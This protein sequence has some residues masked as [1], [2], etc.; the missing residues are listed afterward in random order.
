[1]RAS[2]CLGTYRCEERQ[3]LRKEQERRRQHSMRKSASPLL[4]LC[5]WAV[6]A[7]VVNAKDITGTWYLD[8]TTYNSTNIPLLE[9]AVIDITPISEHNT[10]QVNFTWTDTSGVFIFED[11]IEVSKE[12]R[13]EIQQPVL[14]RIWPYNVYSGIE[15][16][17]SDYRFVKTTGWV[18]EKRMVFQVSGR[19]LTQQGFAPST[20]Y[21]TMDYESNFDRLE[22]SVTSLHPGALLEYVIYQRTK[23]VQDWAPVMVD[24]RVSAL[25]ESQNFRS[26]ETTEAVP[27]RSDKGSTN[28]AYT[29]LLSDAW[30]LESEEF[31][32]NALVIGLQGLVNRNNGAK[33]YLQYPPTWAYSYTPTVQ[34]YFQ[35]RHHF[36]FIALNST[37]DA[38]KTLHASAALKGY[39]IWDIQVRESLVVAYTIAGVENA[40]VVS[41]AQVPLMKAL[42]LPMLVNLTNQFRGLSPVD[43]YSWAK[44]KYW[45]KTS[46]KYLV[47]AGGVGGGSMHPGIMDYGVSEQAFFTDL[48]TLPSDTGEY[49]LAS[50]L[51]SSMDD[52]FYLLGWHS[53][54]KDFEHTFTTLAS[55]YGGRV[56]G[57]NTNPNLSFQSKVSV[58]PGFVFKNN[59]NIPSKKSKLDHTFLE[60]K[61]DEEKTYIL[62]VQTDG[63]GLGAWSKPGR[64]KIPYTWEVT[65]PDLEIQPALLQMFYEQSTEKDFF[66]GALGGPGYTYPNAVPK[67]LL[68]KR[69]QMAASMMSTLDL[70]SFVIFDASRA[71]GTHTVT[72]DTNLDE[73]VVQTYFDAMPNVKGFFNGYAPSF[74]FATSREEHGSRRSLVSFNY[75]LDP[76]RSVESAVKDLEDLSILNK[77]RPFFLEIHVREFSTVGKANDIIQQLSN[78]TFEVLP[79][80]VFVE[81]MN[82][83]GNL[84]ARSGR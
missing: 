83:C 28:T 71:V 34:K 11:S 14:S 38:L 6:L 8:K 39:V 3:R 20:V 53:Y 26:P 13:D 44:N 76:S 5:S 69:L 4:A 65:L 73:D 48:S 16:N 24:A 68:P 33:L 72:G 12:Y 55:K 45:D 19:L 43:I 52:A 2:R 78:Q 37:L 22:F 27:V 23:T 32:M 82:K 15:Y 79:G 36:D 62:L 30:K 42:G 61:C 29:V 10:T 81:T 40:L 59:R 41:A 18:N 7:Y 1:M 47:W 60:K 50:S 51:V 67:K 63:L 54:E 31:Q 25:R 77:K 66:I 84:K 75:Y 17:T 46:K 9:L 80:D 21:F 64:G 56:H 35:D 58:S 70:D 57:L 49:N 74:T